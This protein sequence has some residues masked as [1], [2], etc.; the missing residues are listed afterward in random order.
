MLQLE[1]TS[2]YQWLLT[3][4]SKIFHMLAMLKELPQAH[5][6]RI[7]WLS[8]QP[9]IQP[10]GIEDLHIDVFNNEH[11]LE[12]KGNLEGYEESLDLWEVLPAIRRNTPYMLVKGHVWY[13]ITDDFRT[14][15]RTLADII[16]PR[17]NTLV[18]TIVISLP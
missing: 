1:P 13:S 18:Y 12:I 15:L 8:K 10:L 3:D 7:E 9:S 14:R 17:D 4:P 11:Q 6:N 2:D 16:D 5:H